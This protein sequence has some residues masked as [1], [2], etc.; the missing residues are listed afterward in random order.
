VIEMNLP[1]ENRPEWTT[2]I[3]WK[4][5]DLCMDFWC[6]ECGHHTHFDGFFAYHVQCSNCEA[7]FEMPTDLPVKKVEKAE[8]QMVL[9]GD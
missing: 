5:T 6:P 4:G 3:Q 9:F 8:G 1:P 2:F 7:R